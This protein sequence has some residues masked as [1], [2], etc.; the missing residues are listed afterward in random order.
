[1][2]KGNWLRYLALGLALLAILIA[3]WAGI[4]AF[5]LPKPPN[6]A[7]AQAHHV[8]EHGHRPGGAQCD[9]ERLQQITSREDRQRQ[10]DECADKRDQHEREQND[11]VQQWRSA[12]AAEYTARY[13]FAQLQVTLAESV[14]LLLTLGATAYAAWAAA[15]AARAAGKAVDVAETDLREAN[16]PRLKIEVVTIRMV[17][18]TK[19]HWLRIRVSNLGER[20]AV[21]ES[22]IVDTMS[23]DIDG[24][25]RRP[26]ARIYSFTTEG[27]TARWVIYESRQIVPNG[28]PVEADYARPAPFTSK[29]LGVGAGLLTAPNIYLVG[30]LV[31]RNHLQ[32]RCELGFLFNLEQAYVADLARA[33]PASD[34]DPF[35]NYD[36]EQR[37]EPP[38]PRRA[39]TERIGMVFRAARATWRKSAK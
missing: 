22:C 27:G 12:N 33:T 20:P 36:E 37:P 4:G 38:A 39:L 9:P 29:E 23:L 30:K 8:P 24:W 6:I 31:Y 17:P 32:R 5:L 26:S 15:A 35:Y 28:E 21:V 10:T 11:L 1:M 14:L 25:S 18:D 2:L 16:R 19:E 3:I 34:S 7:E 13:A